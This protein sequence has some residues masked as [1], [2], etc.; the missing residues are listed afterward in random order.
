MRFHGGD[1]G[2]GFSAEIEHG[3]GTGRCAI[4]TESTA[5]ATEYDLRIAAVTSDKY[6]LR[7]GSDTIAAA[8][9]GIGKVLAA[10]GRTALN[11]KEAVATEE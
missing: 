7:A 6:L 10:P 5:F 1:P 2:K 3:F 11:G 4:T 8:G 9:T